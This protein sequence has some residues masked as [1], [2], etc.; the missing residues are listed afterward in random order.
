MCISDIYKITRQP[1]YDESLQSF[2]FRTIGFTPEESAWGKGEM[3]EEKESITL[4]E[5]HHCQAR[6]GTGDGLSY[7]LYQKGHSCLGDKNQGMGKGCG[8]VGAKGVW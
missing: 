1:Y 5:K 3:K 8:L 2:V 4:I 7:G 6:N